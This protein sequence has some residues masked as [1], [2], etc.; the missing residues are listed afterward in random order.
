MA[1]IDHIPRTF[2]PAAQEEELY[3]SWVDARLFHADA[4]SSKP[5]FTVVIPPPNI[6]GQLHIGHALNNTLQDI[7]VRH[8]RMQGFETLWLPGTD[9]ASI[10]TEAR[11]V[12]AM[13][14][15]GVTKEEIGREGFLERAWQW[16]RQY[17][18]QIIEQL[19]RL[20]SSCDW[21]RE[22]F[23][24]DEGLS[25]AVREVFVRLYEEG[26][27]Y[28][29]KRIINWCPHC[30][31]SISD[32]EVEFVEQEG[33]F[34]HIRY[35]LADGT[36]EV[37]V[38][39][40]RPETMLG[41]TAVA[42]HPDD[43]R[44]AALVGQSVI[45][46]LVGRRIPVLADA[47]VDRAFGTGVV[48][49]TPA[50]DPND[51][52]VG[53]RHGLEV[54]DIMTDDAHI[55]AAGGA[56]AGMERYA[57]RKK[58][59]ADLE[60]GG[61][62]VKTEPHRHNVGTCHRC[63]TT[64]EPRVSLQWFVRM[65][66]LAGPAIA[67]VRDGSTRFVPERFEKT[68]LNWMEN[69]RDW[70]V[71]RQLWWGHRIPAYY[72]DACGETL[73]AREAPSACPACG[74]AVRQDEDTLDTWFSSALWPFSTLGWPEQTAD[75]QKFYP[76]SVL[77]TAYDIIFFW[78]ARMVFSGIRQTGQPPFHTVL[79]H[80]LV[81][82]G[83]GRK[84]SKSLGNGIDPLEVIDQYGADALRY[85]LTTGN[86]PGGDT[87]LP[88]EKIEAG[89]NFVNKIWNA[90]RFV[91]MNLDD[92]TRLPDAGNAPLQD[93][94]KWILS[95]L[96]TVT[97]EVTA[98]LDK[99]EMGIALGKIYGF[100]WEEYCDWYIEIVKPRLADPAHPTRAR[101]QHVLVT[102]LEAAMRLLHP[103]MPFLTETIHCGLPGADASIMIS[104]WPTADP[105]HT[106]PLEE[107]RMQIVMDGI[108]SIR[109]V[110]VGMQVPVQRKT[111]II[112]VSADPAILE[113]FAAG[114][115]YVRR[116]ASVEGMEGRADAAGIPDTAVTA[117]FDGGTVYIP[118]GDLID[119]EKEKERLRKE[120]IH[121]Q[122]ERDRVAEK[123]SNPAFTTR[124]P[125]R[126]VD[127]EKAKLARYGA[128]VTDLE[129]RLAAL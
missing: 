76:T 41:D 39:T 54:V 47:Y 10:A 59:V 73:V 115:A 126:V 94:D 33:S 49:I 87:R 43:E 25:R 21:E 102:V 111:N 89:R 124:A 12:A 48:K 125:A 109:N 81:R 24:M 56:Y 107:R 50:H 65:Q 6:T 31:T 91:L 34:W 57:A 70:C 127:A 3:K 93:E 88:A 106:Y 71:S 116:L 55:A 84:M 61:Y 86:A 2:E 122:Q 5:P 100:I 19:K 14:R 72:C 18:G 40:T 42:V 66:P 27:V 51:Y 83:Q 62:L 92:L 98:N 129:K 120:W 32:T 60:A 28:R 29:G 90:Y 58:I 77:V 11:I 4:T 112:V 110:R 16:R 30:L 17:G 37:V 97:A 103:Y 69:I 80:G 108:R 123:L 104:A 78:V 53:L 46:P 119:V 95:R 15:E 26:L 63:H 113:S 44:Y 118:L 105:A 101:A 85:A 121:A 20:G 79:I 67:A 117:V 68:Y 8:K 114:S 1:N 38:A 13:A 74:G 22:R 23:T 96:N 75:L 64:V 9:H 35:P 128:M 45:L 52:E 7:L 99:Y 36:G 82:D